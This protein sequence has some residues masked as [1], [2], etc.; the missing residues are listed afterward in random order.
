[1]TENPYSGWKWSTIF[2]PGLTVYIVHT[3]HVT[4]EHFKQIIGYHWGGGQ[5]RF[6]ITVTIKMFDLVYDYFLNYCFI[7]VSKSGDNVQNVMLV[8]GRSFSQMM[9]MSG[10]RSNHQMIR[11][12]L[13]N[14]QFGDF[15]KILLSNWNYNQSRF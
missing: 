10:S 14:V 13:V 5:L 1:M 6:F 2:L 3:P 8:V 4:L 15:F 7:M 9:N 11:V 12:T